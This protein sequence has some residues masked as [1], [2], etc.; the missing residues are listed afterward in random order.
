MD[1]RIGTSLHAGLLIAVVGTLAWAGLPALFPSLG[2]SAFVLATRPDA[3]ASRPQRV[4]GGHVVG[5]LTGLAAYHA[6]AAPIAVT[7]S[8]SPFSIAW[9]R[10]AASATVATALTAGGMLVTDLH[11]APACATTLI[12][13][14][15]I[16]STPVG[17]G[18]IVVAVALL[19][20]VNRIAFE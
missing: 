8:L 12:V 15:G 3:A 9:L 18:V 20:G 7:D 17:G 4:I 13:A 10:L 14:L 16:Q 19:V 6:L 5:V 1:R 11:H 2:P